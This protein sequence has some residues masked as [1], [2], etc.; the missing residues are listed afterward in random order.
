MAD[1]THVCT[2]DWVAKML[3]EYPELLEVIDDQRSVRVKR[4]PSGRSRVFRD[5]SGTLLN[6]HDLDDMEDRGRNYLLALRNQMTGCR[7]ESAGAR[8]VPRAS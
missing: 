6:I 5:R 4:A 1:V 3:G 8:L 7:V 2:L